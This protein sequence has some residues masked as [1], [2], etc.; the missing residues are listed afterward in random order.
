MK[1]TPDIEKQ[2]QKYTLR[3]TR[4]HSKSYPNTYQNPPQIPPKSTQKWPL[5]LPWAP[6]VPTLDT[7]RISR[8]FWT[9]FFDLFDPPGVP[10]GPR[11]GP[12]GVQRGTKIVKNVKKYTLRS[13]P[14]KNHQKVTNWDPPEPPLFNSRSR[15]VNKITK[16]PTLQNCTQKSPK[17]L[18]NGTPRES[19]GTKKLFQRPLKNDSEKEHEKVTKKD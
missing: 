3:P 6:L 14:T 15:G 13:T 9:S 2:I 17:C 5:G 10:K 18:Q 8:P 11:W 16:P 7:M 1:S 19:L 12:T 4:N